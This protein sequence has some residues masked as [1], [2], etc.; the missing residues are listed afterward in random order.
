MTGL[1]RAL[2]LNDGEHVLFFEKKQLRH[3][4][5]ERYI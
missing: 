3:Y 1:F 5:I 2:I 4:I